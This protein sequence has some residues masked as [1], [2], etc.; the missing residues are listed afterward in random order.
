M[1]F[2]HNLGFKS[3]L[4]SSIP[5]HY[6]LSIA[7]MC[8]CR[9]VWLEGRSLLIWKKYIPLPNTK[10]TTSCLPSSFGSSHI[11]MEWKQ[12][13][14]PAGRY[15]TKRG[16]WSGWM[17]VA[18]LPPWEPTALPSHVHPF[19]LLLSSARITFILFASNSFVLFAWTTS[20][21]SKPATHPPSPTISSQKRLSARISQSLL[22]QLP[23]SYPPVKGRAEGKC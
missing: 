1:L 17:L 8:P 14:R 16:G 3:L 18:F 5:L 10:L 20:V 6:P 11:L 2:S 19:T 12:E 4:P 23:A 22:F 9:S 13:K 15:G 21:P 7:Y